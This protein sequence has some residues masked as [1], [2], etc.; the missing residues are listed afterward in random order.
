MEYIE[1]FKQLF[2]LAFGVFIALV[3]AFYIIWPKIEGHFLKMGNINQ[4]K[5]LL[6]DRLQLRFAA[7][8]RLLLFVHRVSP[9]QLMLRHHGAGVTL[10]QF[11]QAILTD[12]ESEFQHNFTQQLYVSDVAWAI[13][14]GLKDNTLELMRNA[15]KGMGGE[16]TVDS[17]IEVVLKHMKTLDVNPYEAAQV[18]LKKELAA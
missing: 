13:V 4:N 15:N 2:V 16:G 10:H 3:L 18:L 7:Y 8:E 11:K 9:E 6:K 5:E 12:I 14:K 17:Y 1:F